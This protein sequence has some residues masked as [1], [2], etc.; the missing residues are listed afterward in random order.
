M[1]EAERN[2]ERVSEEISGK[3]TLV[4]EKNNEVVRLQDA[5]LKENV[6]KKSLCKEAAT[7][8][9]RLTDEVFPERDAAVRSALD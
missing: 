6:E 9:A 3:E 2:A 5:T 4:H 8:S 7:V 1:R